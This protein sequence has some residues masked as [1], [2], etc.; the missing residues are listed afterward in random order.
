[1]PFPF[2]AAATIA[3]P[4]VQSLIQNRMNRNMS[5]YAYSKDLAMWEKTN[6][7]NSPKMQMQ[8]YGQAGLNP[9][10]IY[11]QGNAGNAPASMPKYTP[12]DR[13]IELPN[14]MGVLQQF[15][16]FALKSKKLD[17]MKE[18][19]D[20]L[21]KKELNIDIINALKNLELNTKDPL[22][23]KSA[24]EDGG[25]GSIL[26]QGTKSQT[27]YSLD[28]QRLKNVKSEQELKVILNK[29]GITQ[30]QKNWLEYKYQQM[31][32]TSI[33]IDKDVVWQRIL[34]D[35]FGD[36]IKSFKDKF[37]PTFKF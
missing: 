6:E 26:P 18:Q 17:I 19:Y 20:I 22:A 1:M 24:M 34:A 30:Q 11:Q 15:Q 28:A 7:Y 9:N 4:L 8:R 2:L 35:F 3:A 10:L 12:P 33:N 14:A 5:E 31:I 13:K 29:I 36:Q 16:D 21:E 32:N 37:K 23:F 25:W 27:E